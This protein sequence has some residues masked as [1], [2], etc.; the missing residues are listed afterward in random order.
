MF[1]SLARNL[2]RSDREERDD[3]LHSSFIVT[4]APAR[5]RNPIVLGPRIGAAMVQRRGGGK[6]LVWLVLLLIVVSIAAAIYFFGIPAELM[7]AL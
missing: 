3:V 6:T 2:I 7:R 4:K 5:K 1:A